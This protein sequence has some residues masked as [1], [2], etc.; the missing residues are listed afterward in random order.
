MALI[1]AKSGA[2]VTIIA[3]NVEKLEKAREEIL[4][5]RA[6]HK[7]FNK[8]HYYY[9]SVTKVQISFIL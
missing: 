2:H 8:V 5:V 7:D 4:K 3:R 9:D 1:A 6:C